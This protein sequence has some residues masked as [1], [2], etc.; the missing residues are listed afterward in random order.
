MVGG[1]L[2]RHRMMQTRTSLVIAKDSGKEDKTPLLQPLC[3]AVL[4][5]LDITQFVRDGMTQW[6]R[7]GDGGKHRAMSLSDRVERKYRDASWV[8]GQSPGRLPNSALL[9]QYG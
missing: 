7:R 5:S 9:P 2:G 4:V 6:C 3:S 8:G 1:A